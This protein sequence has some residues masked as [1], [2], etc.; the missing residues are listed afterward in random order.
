[1][2]AALIASLALAPTMHANAGVSSQQALLS[3][4]VHPGQTLTSFMTLTD[5]PARWM[6]CQ[7]FCHPPSQS[8]VVACTIG[9]IERGAISLQRRVRAVFPTQV[10]PILEHPPIVM[11]GG[12]A[13]R[14][15]GPALNTDPI[16]PIYSID[17]WGTPTALLRIGT[18]W[19]T[20][21]WADVK[22]TVAVRDIDAETGAISLHVAAPQSYSVDMVVSKG[23]I[24]LSETD[25]AQSGGFD[26]IVVST[27]QEDSLAELWRIPTTKPLLVPGDLHSEIL[28]SERLR[29]WHF[30]V[31]SPERL[32]RFLTDAKL[33]DW[34]LFFGAAVLVVLV[35]RA[36]SMV[37]QISKPSNRT[38][39]PAGR[40]R[41]LLEIVLGL[42]I[43]AACMVWVYR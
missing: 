3:P 41:L 12:R 4:R 23:G 11:R 30:G 43:A 40:W 36:E 17:V 22:G 26:E 37:V 38:L 34:L 2:I 35:S 32:L 7:G 20:S 31:F 14:P 28:R 24:I 16:C 25:R 10:G 39:R 6:R 5:T 13:F 9:S 27:L 29:A 18:S 8:M 33:S 21:T 42:A 15:D 1:M 19:P